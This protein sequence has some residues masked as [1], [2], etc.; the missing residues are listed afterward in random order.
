MSSEVMEICGDG[1]EYFDYKELIV[2]YVYF[3]KKWRNFAC[4]KQKDCTGCN[5]QVLPVH[6]EFT[7]L[8]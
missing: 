8:L 7:A 4:L 6:L 2:M 5:L 1:G 3:V